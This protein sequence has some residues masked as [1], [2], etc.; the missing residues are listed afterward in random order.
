MFQRKEYLITYFQQ[1]VARKRIIM[2]NNKT[3]IPDTQICHINNL[4]R[5]WK[6][7]ISTIGVCADIFVGGNMTHGVKY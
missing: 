1:I 6:R 2:Q 4:W 7:A 5:G 3:T